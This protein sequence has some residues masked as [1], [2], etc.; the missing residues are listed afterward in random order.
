MRE[1]FPTRLM[2]RLFEAT[3]E[4]LAAIEPL[5]TPLPGGEQG[6]PAAPATPVTVA[7]LPPPRAPAGPAYVFRWNGRMWE[8]VFDSLGPFY[9]ANTLGAKYLNHLLH[10]ANEPITAF[11]L[12]VV[13]QPAKGEARSTNSIQ[14]RLDGPARREYGQ[15]LSA[16]PAK[17]VR[18]AGNPGE[19]RRLEGEIQALESALKQS[20]GADDTGERARGNVRRAINAVLKQL[21]KRGAA[22]QAFAAHLRSQVS[23]GYECLY[24]QAEGRI[25]A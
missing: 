19:V 5:L 8:V 24:S 15:E 12:E 16:L 17:Q 20:R 4:V 25:W 11:G 6:A 14:D 3:P 23:T 13:I 7:G 10:S 1:T 21:D 18:A 22:E 2:L 9:L